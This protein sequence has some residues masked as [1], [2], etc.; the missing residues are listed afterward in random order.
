MMM[1][2]MTRGKKIRLTP[3]MKIG[4]RYKLEVPK[5]LH[6]V[7]PDSRNRRGSIRN[8]CP[9]LRS[10]KTNKSDNQIKRKLRTK[11]T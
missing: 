3:Q 5:E 1:M 11:P 7:C 6:K 2:G 9:T 10:R 4:N 8:I